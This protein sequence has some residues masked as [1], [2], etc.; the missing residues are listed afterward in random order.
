MSSA[1]FLRETQSVSA[2]SVI[3]AHLFGLP[4]ARNT[5]APVEEIDLV[6]AA[7][8]FLKTRIYRPV[9]PGTYPTLLMRVPYGFSGFGTVAEAFAEQGYNSII[10]ACRGTGG[11]T[12][13]FDPLRNER[14][15]GLATLDWL[16]RQPW[17]DGRLGL[18]GP[19]YLGYAQWAI[20]DALPET[21]AMAIQASSANFEPIVFPGESFSLQ[22]WLSWLQIVQGLTDAPMTAGLQIAIG[23]IERVTYRAADKLPLINAD[24]EV[25][26]HKVPFWQRWFR[27]AIDNPKFWAPLNQTKRMSKTTPPN[28][29]VSG[30]YDL[31]L[32]GLLSDYQRLVALGHTPYLTIG[33]W[34]HITPELQVESVRATIPWMRAHL[35]ND[36]SLLRVNPVRIE[37]SGGIG[38]REFAQFPPPGITKGGLYLHEAG[39]LDSAP[40]EDGQPLNYTYDPAHPTP[41]VGGAYFAFSGAG[42][43]DNRKLEARDDVLVFTSGAL[44]E[45]VV[46]IGQVEVTLYAASSSAN[47]DFFV[48]ICDVSTT[49]TSTNISDAI[50]RIRP[51]EHEH[52]SSGVMKLSF[53]LH[54]CA[55]RFARGHK[56]RLQVSSGAHPRFARNLGT[57][58][59]IGTATRMVKQE[60]TV[61]STASGADGV[62][63]QPAPEPGHSADIVLTSRS[64]LTQSPVLQ[65]GRA[66]GQNGQEAQGRV[67]LAYRRRGQR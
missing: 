45:D 66:R 58:E 48:R 20:C 9:E 18:S 31:M 19:S 33:N 7:G 55:H 59:P 65:H 44:L 17:Y 60:Q 15:D 26:G 35:E 38:W 34:H 27:E 6:A 4:P 2:G 3:L 41:S 63:R 42:P 5:A 11:S 16:K 14:A 64:T 43:M 67:A 24:T 32:E 40:P 57:G 53:T 62:F 52:D 8:I 1:R 25:V 54:H 29:F 30:W 28:H 37:I 23:N 61:F 10:Q 49:G 21:S 36:P 51:G 13:E 39:R 12:G 46:V 50:M 56:I 47:T 22:L